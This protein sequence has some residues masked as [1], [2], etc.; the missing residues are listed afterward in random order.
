[1]I[2]A[3]LIRIEEQ[4]SLMTRWIAMIGL[5]CLVILTVATIAD[6]LMRWL[7]NSPIDGVYDLYKLVIALVI[8][9]FFPITLIERHHIAIS[10]LG[11]ASKPWVNAW[12]NNFA[13]M[14]LLL[15]LLA[16]SWQL[17]R[18]VIEV[19][20]AGETTWILQ[21]PIAPWWGVATICIILCI[22]VQLF[23]TIKDAIHPRRA[24]HHAPPKASDGEA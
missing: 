24:N 20:D 23:V 9:A 4:I 17:V 14:S 22:P 21:W 16:M 10:F 2:V 15:F 13:N 11:G 1:M 18:Y 3:S 19:G 8:G 6:V 12:L 5:A 7:F